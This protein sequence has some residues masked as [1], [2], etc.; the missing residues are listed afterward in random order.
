MRG[1][2]SSTWLITT[3]PTILSEMLIGKE[4]DEKNEKKLLA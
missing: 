1:I 3:M 2:I 4:K